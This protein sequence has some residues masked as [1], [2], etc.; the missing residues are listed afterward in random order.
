MMAALLATGRAALERLD[1]VL[2]AQ[3]FLLGETPTIADLAVYGYAH[4]RGRGR[5][6]GLRR[7]STPGASASARCPGSAG[8][9][10]PY[11]ENSMA[12]ASRSIYD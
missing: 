6:R 8:E 10:A 1:A 3:S 4:R 2:A 11:P 12:G 9:L 7:R 5:A